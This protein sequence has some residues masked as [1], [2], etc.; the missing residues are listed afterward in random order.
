MLEQTFEY[1][2]RVDQL[3]EIARKTFDT[4][5][6]RWNPKAHWLLDREP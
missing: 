1:L 5:E 3:F 6:K 2:F 4:P